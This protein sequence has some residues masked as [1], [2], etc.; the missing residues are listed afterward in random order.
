MIKQIL[1]IKVEI[2]SCLIMAISLNIILD[3]LQSPFIKLFIGIL[4]ARIYLF[5]SY[6]LNSK[7]YLLIKGEC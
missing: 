4:L 1:D 5:S 6:L 7:G 2:I 3:Y